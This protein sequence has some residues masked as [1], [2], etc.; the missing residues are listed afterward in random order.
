MASFSVKAIDHVVLT[1]KDVDKTV[2]FYTTKLGMKH[3]TFKS[4]GIERHALTFGNQKLNLHLSGK[5]FE[6]KAQ[7]VQP[8]SED[9]CFITDTLIDE[10][11]SSWKSAGIEILEG[12]QVVERTGAV[13]K[14]RSV[15]T[16]DPDGNLIE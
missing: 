6:P 14:L 11:L 7:H 13:G 9:L 5:E 12:G 1:A 2:E 16:R 4:N 10:V 3:E 8:G 15:Y